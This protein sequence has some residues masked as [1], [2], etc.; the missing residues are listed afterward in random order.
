MSRRAVSGESIARVVRDERSAASRSPFECKSSS[1]VLHTLAGEIASR[2]RVSP[3]AANSSLPRKRRN[4]DA[5]KLPFNAPLPGTRLLPTNAPAHAGP[6]RLHDDPLAPI[7]DKQLGFVSMDH[8]DDHKCVQ[9][10][11]ALTLRSPAESRY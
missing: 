3:D 7:S 10:P 2:A 5:H 4:S 8:S 11:P 6:H 9:T 1:I